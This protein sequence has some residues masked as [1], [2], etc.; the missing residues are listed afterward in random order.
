MTR[1]PNET[2]NL[3]LNALHALS[4][5][6]TAQAQQEIF[7]YIEIFYN[8]QRR[9]SANDYLSPDNYEMLLKVA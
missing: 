8:R 3:T 4:I 9:H 6:G 1:N 5:T 2:K 7:E